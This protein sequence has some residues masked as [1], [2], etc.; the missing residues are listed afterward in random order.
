MADDNRNGGKNRGRLTSLVGTVVKTR[1]DKTAVV[2]VASAKK[3]RVYNRPVSRRT[4][5]IVHDAKSRCAVG[6]RA[7]IY[8]SKPV[9]KTKRWRVGKIVEKSAAVTAEGEGR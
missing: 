4:R 5:Y 6:D 9:S 3:H 1:A 8:A 2:D 7:L